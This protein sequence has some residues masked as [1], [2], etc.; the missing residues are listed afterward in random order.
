[1]K[2]TNYTKTYILSI[3]FVCF[4][5]LSRKAT[6]PYFFYCKYRNKY[7]KTKEIREKNNVKLAFSG[8]ISPARIMLYAHDNDNSFSSSKNCR[9]KSYNAAQNFLRHGYPTSVMRL[10]TL[11][12]KAKMILF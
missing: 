1:M 3:S 5:C 6:Q 12:E 10:T 2:L 7:L 9:Q 11:Y 8:F 4:S